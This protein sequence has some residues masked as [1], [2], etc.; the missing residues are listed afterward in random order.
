M[1]DFSSDAI[2]QLI[3]AIGYPGIFAMIL[4]ETGVIFGFFLPGSSFVFAT[5][6]LAA[7]GVLN[8]WV[9]IPVVAVA[10][11]LG[12]CLGYWFGWRVGVALFSRPDSRFFKYSYLE[13]AKRFY[14]AHGGKA[15]FLGR[16]IPTVRTFVPV[17]A[18]IVRMRLPY[19]MAL[20]VIGSIA[21]SAGIV[22]LGY[23]IGDAIPHVERYVMALAALFLL[24]TG[25][26]LFWELRA[27][28]K[29]PFIRGDA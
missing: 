27:P 26:P 25:V 4:V 18:G 2:P 21:W 8:P 14:D 12:D 15:I 23:F 13:T 9:L 10:A 16:F 22:L 17:I 5:G 29:D 6:V 28:Q 3:T 19:F 20:N 24:I 1:P 7:A 11:F